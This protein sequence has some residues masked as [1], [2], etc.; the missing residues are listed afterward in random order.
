[1]QSVSLRRHVFAATPRGKRICA[2]LP[3]HELHECRSFA[4]NTVPAYGDARICAP[5]R[6]RNML[7]RHFKD[8][9]S[10]VKRT[11]RG[12]CLPP[13]LAGGERTCRSLLSRLQP[14]FSTLREARLKPAQGTKCLTV[15]H[16]LKSVANKALIV[17]LRC[18]RERSCHWT[19]SRSSAVMSSSSNVN[20]CPHSEQMYVVLPTRL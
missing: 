20:G 12:S 4:G 11:G 10:S 9:S 16:R 3:S 7:S 13:A 2:V 8:F 18:L 14:G 6:L 5:E 19:G 17:R 1:M 15:D